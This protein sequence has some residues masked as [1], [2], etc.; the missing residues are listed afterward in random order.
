MMSD[1]VERGAQ[2]EQSGAPL[3]DTEV[4]ASQRPPSQPDSDI[5]AGSDGSDVQ[6]GSADVPGAGLVDQQLEDPE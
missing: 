1:Q 4:A 5:D 2:E 6:E 3:T